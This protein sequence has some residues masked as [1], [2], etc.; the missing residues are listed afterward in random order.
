VDEVYSRA[1]DIRVAVFDVDGVLTDGRLYVGED[2]VEMIAFSIADGLGLKMLRA[3]GIEWAIITGR[4][5]RAVELRAHSLGCVYLYQGIDDKL[6]KLNELLA[7]VDMQPTAAAYIGDD[8]VDLPCLTRVGLAIAVPT[9]PALVRQH[10]H[11]VTEA[12]GGAGAAREVCD[13]IMRAQGKLDRQLSPYV[14]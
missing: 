11:Y 5:S 4:K 3:S 12:H 13:L 8:V 7:L 2:G 9:A 14:A 1:R 10:A 6:R